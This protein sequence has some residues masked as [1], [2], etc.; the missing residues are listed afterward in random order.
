MV[1]SGLLKADCVIRV[2]DQLVAQQRQQPAQ[3]QFSM[4][5]GSRIAFAS[6]MAFA[7]MHRLRPTERGLGQRFSSCR[8]QNQN[9]KLAESCQLSSRIKL[10]LSCTWGICTRRAGKLYKARS[11]LYRSKQASKYV[12]FFPEKK[13]DTSIRAQLKCT[14]P[15]SK[16]TV[17]SKFSLE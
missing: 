7:G 11:R 9:R 13:R 3:G 4:P 12:R 5:L 6:R 16:P 1:I 10:Q 17:A 8:R 15:D 2:A 14:R